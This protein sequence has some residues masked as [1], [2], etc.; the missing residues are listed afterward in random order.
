MAPT[1]SPAGAGRGGGGS[2]PGD[3]NN[4]GPKNNIPLV[5]IIIVLIVAA[6]FLASVAICVYKRRQARERRRRRVAQRYSRMG[7]YDK[8]V[9]SS[10]D[11]GSRGHR[12]TESNASMSVYAT[13]DNPLPPLPAPVYEVPRVQMHDGGLGPPPSYRPVDADTSANNPWVVGWR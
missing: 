4:Q 6:I 2:S 10:S 1:P 7:T 13:S 5:A 9:G 3:D 11:S 12:S 8:V